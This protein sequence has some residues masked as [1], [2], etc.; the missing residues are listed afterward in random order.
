MR[1]CVKY[2][3]K[4]KRSFVKLK[5][6]FYSTVNGCIFSIK[7]SL[8][9]LIFYWHEQKSNKI[10]VLCKAL[11]FKKIYKQHEKLSLIKKINAQNEKKV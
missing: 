7:P 6:V 4:I 11:K 1:A 3:I 9:I 2:G 8:L 5:S 10:Y